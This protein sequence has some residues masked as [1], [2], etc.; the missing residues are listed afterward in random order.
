MISAPYELIDKLMGIKNFSVKKHSFFWGK[1][2]SDKEIDF[3]GEIVKL[4]VMFG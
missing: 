2:S 1:G 3:F 4:K